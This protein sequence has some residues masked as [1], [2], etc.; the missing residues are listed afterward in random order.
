MAGALVVKM[1]QA[2]VGTF[3]PTWIEPGAGS[4]LVRGPYDLRNVQLYQGWDAYAITPRP[5]K[6]R[7]DV[8]IRT[9]L[10][11]DSA[12]TARII[13][14]ASVAEQRKSGRE[15]GAPILLLIDDLAKLLA[16]R[17]YQ[18]DAY[19]RWLLVYGASQDIQVIAQAGVKNDLGRVGSCFAYTVKA[20]GP[21][22]LAGYP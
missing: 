10:T 18:N 6:G 11:Y 8:S 22:K 2:E 15:R 13:E 5:H 3:V 16:Y 14:L 17:D 9:V 7:W 19:L 4:I 21:D 20:A 12:S 1:F